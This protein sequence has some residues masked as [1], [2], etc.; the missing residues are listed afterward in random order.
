MVFAIWWLTNKCSSLVLL[1]NFGAI[2]DEGILFPPH[3]KCLNRYGIF[4]KAT[5][6]LIFKIK[7]K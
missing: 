7:K 4:E 2:S 5:E 3:R 6:F 1:L